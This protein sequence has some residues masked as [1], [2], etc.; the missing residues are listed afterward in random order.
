MQEAAPASAAP[1][2]SGGYVDP[3]A[4]IDQE[5]NTKEE[6]LSAGLNSESAEAL[7]AGSNFAPN[8][9]EASDLFAA[10]VAEKQQDLSSEFV[11]IIF[12]AL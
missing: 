10:L 2:S 7:A 4:S 9:A 12:D 3:F 6:A 1:A 8:R 5:Q 11:N